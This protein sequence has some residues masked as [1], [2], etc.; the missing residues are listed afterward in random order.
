[1]D[2]ANPSGVEQLREVIHAATPEAPLRIV[3]GRSLADRMSP[4]PGHARIASSAALDAVAIDAPN[5]IA[6][7]QAGVSLAA[8]VGTLRGAAWCG[9][10]NG[11]SREEP[12]VGWSRPAVDRR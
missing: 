6:R 10:L 11:S 8:L 9:R 12:S 3:G 1:M 4:P 5:L 2:E 7:V